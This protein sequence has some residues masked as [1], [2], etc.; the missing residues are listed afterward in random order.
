MDPIPT[1]QTRRLILIPLELRDAPAIQRLFPHWE[2]VRYLGCRVPW[3]YPGDGSQTY[4]RDHAL[5]A[6]AAG[7][8]WHW[9]IR[10][11]EDPTQIIGS[12]HLYDEPGNNRGFWLAPQWQGQGYMSE[13][14]EVINAYWFETLERP[15][16]QVSKAVG[17]LASRR[18]SEREGMRMIGTQQGE[19]VCGPLLKEVWEMTREAWLKAKASSNT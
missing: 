10:I 4:V 1:F 11:A 12:I 2:V 8:E 15:V 13:A 17:N 19:F 16:M 7:R 9:M 3:P 5:P 6:V 18:V 14:C